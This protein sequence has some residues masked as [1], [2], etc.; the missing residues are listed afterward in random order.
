MARLPVKRRPLRPLQKH[1]FVL[2]GLPQTPT[3]IRLDAA[4]TSR[5]AARRNV[6]VKAA[7]L[8]PAFAWEASN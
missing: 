3:V 6:L 2:R 5:K 4:G 8:F 1:E 7:T